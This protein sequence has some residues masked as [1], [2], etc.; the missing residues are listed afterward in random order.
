MGSKRLS[1]DASEPIQPGW[2]RALKSREMDRIPLEEAKSRDKETRDSTDADE[3]VGRK[4]NSWSSYV[5]LVMDIWSAAR[6]RRGYNTR[7]RRKIDVELP[8]S[9][10]KTKSSISA[11]LLTETAMKVI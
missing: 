9:C 4:R 5:R 3:T 1:P 8:L 11:V 6:R 2:Y 10:I 7:S